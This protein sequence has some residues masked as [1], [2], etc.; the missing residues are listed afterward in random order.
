[1]GCCD[2][3]DDGEEDCTSTSGNPLIFPT[4]ACDVVGVA[5]G[6]SFDLPFPPQMLAL[7]PL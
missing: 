6:K 1:M 5:M 2:F 3:T 7:K 4:T